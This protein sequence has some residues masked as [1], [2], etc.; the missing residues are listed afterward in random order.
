MAAMIRIA[1]LPTL[2][3][4]QSTTSHPDKS[5]QCKWNQPNKRQQHHLNQSVQRTR[6][7]T[8]STRRFYD[9]IQFQIQ[10]DAKRRQ[11]VSIRNIFT[12]KNHS[13]TRQKITPLFLFRPDLQYAIQF[14]TF[15]EEKKTPYMLSVA[16]PYIK[17]R[18]DPTALGACPRRT[19]RTDF[20]HCFNKKQSKTTQQDC[21]LRPVCRTLLT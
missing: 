6:L 2:N 21:E 7:H 16:W 10:S 11:T 9:Q 17:G 19:A 20:G 3:L 1:S 13:Q 15:I 12:F 4:F 18:I 8:E 14:D 5:L